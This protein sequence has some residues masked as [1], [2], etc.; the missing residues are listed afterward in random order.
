[1]EEIRRAIHTRHFSR[2]HYKKILEK[3]DTFK[4]Q[5]H[6][7]IT[8]KNIVTQKSLFK[9][10]FRNNNSIITYNYAC[11]NRKGY[12][13]NNRN[14]TNRHK[15]KIHT[16]TL[17]LAKNELELE[18]IIN[19]SKFKDCDI[20]LVKVYSH[21]D[22]VIRYIFDGHHTILSN[23]NKYSFYSYATCTGKTKAKYL[24]SLTDTTTLTLRQQIS[25]LRFSGITRIRI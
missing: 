3:C 11:Y 17:V 8:Y 15:A 13:K 24:K 9:S 7:I 22:D 25:L 1:M 6:L 10:L 16:H 20:K 21:I 18:N 12:S 23:S 4:Y 19:M 5:Y 2:L 14:N